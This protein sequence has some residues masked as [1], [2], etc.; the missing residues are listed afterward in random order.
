MNMIRHGHR[1]ERAG[2][3]EGLDPAV[4]KIVRCAHIRFAVGKTL[5]MLQMPA[6]EPDMYKK[7]MIGSWSVRNLIDRDAQDILDAVAVY[8]D[9]PGAHA[10]YMR[11]QR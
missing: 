1:V 2:Y 8:R 9:I 4:E 11:A 10:H 5:L 3:I 6:G 7:R